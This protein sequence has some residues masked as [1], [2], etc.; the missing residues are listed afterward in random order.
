VKYILFRADSGLANRLRALV[1]YHT[2]ALAR[3]AV[4]L[5]DWQINDACN[6]AFGELFV[7]P[8]PNTLL[9]TEDLPLLAAS[10]KDRLAF[11]RR[12]YMFD[13]IWNAHGREFAS[14]QDFY[15]ESLAM[16]ANIKPAPDLQDTIQRIGDAIDVGSRTG[17]HIRMTD[18]LKAFKD[19]KRFEDF[20]AKKISRL[21]GFERLIKRLQAENERVFL[22]TDNGDVERRLLNSFSNIAVAEKDYVTPAVGANGLF[23]RFRGFSA[24]NPAHSAT[25]GAHN[26]AGGKDCGIR[27]TGMDHAIIDMFLLSKCN[28]VVCSYYSSFGEIAALLGSTKCLRMDGCDLAIHPTIN[29]FRIYYA[30]GDQPIA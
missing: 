5:V 23:A 7:N 12:T 24:R 14:Q 26:S 1:G 4:L 27:T 30:A 10:E 18:N 16:L 11:Y 28:A 3:S 21:K 29:Q 20:E 15:R 22:S 19:W 13:A 8:N 9:F 25:G 2:L 17:V 6:R